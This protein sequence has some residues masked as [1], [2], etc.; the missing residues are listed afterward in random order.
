[1]I[2]RASMSCRNV[3]KFRQ[4]IE[5]VPCVLP[6]PHHPHRGLPTTTTTT[7]APARRPYLS[8]VVAHFKDGRLPA[9]FAGA[10]GVL[11]AVLQGVGGAAEAL[12][13]Q[14]AHPAALDLELGQIRR[15]GGAAATGKR[16]G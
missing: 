12:S 6:L 5:L 16:S 4:T 1:M 13:L 2:C 15:L 14:L 11:L 7:T 9:D 3:G 8:A 10:V